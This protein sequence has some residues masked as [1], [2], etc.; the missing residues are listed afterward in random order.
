MGPLLFSIFVN[1]LPRSLTCKVVLYADDSAI[2]F[3]SDN[4]DEMSSVLNDDLLSVEKW[5]KRN[6]LSLNVSKT[7]YM[8]CSTE[9]SVQ[10]FSNVSLS[11]HDTEIERVTSFKY[12][13]TWIDPILKW[14]EHVIN[15]SKKISQRI[16]FISRLRKS[17]PPK[18]TKL[19]AN[20]LVMPYF[21]YCNLVW[22]NCTNELRNK[23]QVLQNRLARIILYEGPRAHVSDMLNQL[24]WRNLN[25]RSQFNLILLV[26][27]CLTGNT[28]DYLKETIN[29]V[30]AHHSYGT[31]S[32]SNLSLYHNKVKTQ[33]GKRTF[34]YRGTTAWNNLPP[35]IRSISNS[36]VFKQVLRNMY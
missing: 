7:K 22:N 17:L 14:D 11:I 3:S 30:N 1:D 10:N 31:K 24:S 18:V 20:S 25:D 33:A 12:L 15:T 35:D 27:K 26:H 23:L 5:L 2:M 8:I 13:G 21:D 32:S 29:Y 16:G 36:D 19:L 34:H 4:A 6:K 28:P 9:R